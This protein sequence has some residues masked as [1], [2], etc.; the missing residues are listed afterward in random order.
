MAGTAVD[1]R[2][3]RRAAVARM[4]AIPGHRRGLN[5][6]IFAQTFKSEARVGVYPHQLAANRGIH[7]FQFA[8][9]ELCC[10]DS[11]SENYRRR[12][13]SVGATRVP[14]ASRPLERAPNRPA[15]GLGPC[16]GSSLRARPGTAGGAPP[17]PK[18]AVLGP[19]ETIMSGDE[20]VVKQTPATDVPNSKPGGVKMIEA[21]LGLLSASI[22]V[23]HAVDAY[24]T[25]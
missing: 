18:P 4:R 11:S 14:P 5:G 25:P 19:H 10:Q 9:D 2:N 12:H 23:A 7:A 16:R 22:F 13:F 21:I 24:R 17:S 3:E 6:W 20:A 1:G 15:Y 8:R